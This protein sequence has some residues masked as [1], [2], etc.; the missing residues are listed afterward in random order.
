M[1]F[2]F[3]FVGDLLENG[4]KAITGALG[5]LWEIIWDEILNPILEP[6]MGLLGIEDE[7][8]LQVSVS[9]APYFDPDEHFISTLEKGIIKAILDDYDIFEGA[10]LAILNNITT[11][12]RRYYN[13]GLIGENKITNSIP[14]VSVGDGYINGLPEGSMNNA[15]INAVNDDVLDILYSL[16]ADAITIILNNLTVR[17]PTIVEQV[18]NAL[19]ASEPTWD[20]TQY[21]ESDVTRPAPIPC[22]EYTDVCVNPQPDPTFIINRYW[23]FQGSPTD[24]N[25]HGATAY[26]S[27][28][29]VCQKNAEGAPGLDSCLSVS[30]ISNCGQNSIQ[31]WETI[32]SVKPAY[33]FSYGGSTFTEQKDIEPA[34]CPHPT[35]Q[36]YC[37]STAP[38]TCPDEIYEQQCTDSWD[39]DECYQE[40]VNCVTDGGFETGG[41]IYAYD[42]DASGWP[43]IDFLNTTNDLITNLGC[44]LT[45]QDSMWVTQNN[46]QIGIHVGTGLPTGFDSNDWDYTYQNADD[47]GCTGVGTV[48]V[49]HEKPTSTTV[50]VTDVCDTYPSCCPPIDKT[51]WDTPDCWREGVN[52]TPDPYFYSGDDYYRSFFGSQDWGQTGGNPYFLTGTQAV[53]NEIE[54]YWKG[55]LGYFDAWLVSMEFDSTFPDQINYTVGY[56]EVSGGNTYTSGPNTMQHNNCAYMDQQLYPCNQPQPDVCDTY[57]QC[58]EP[59]GQGGEICDCA[60]LTGPNGSSY[61]YNETTERYDVVDQTLDVTWEYTSETIDENGDI[62]A[63]FVDTVDPS[64]TITRAISQ[65]STDIFYV[66]DYTITGGS[67]DGQTLTW[68]YG[69]SEGTYPQLADNSAYDDTLEDGYQFLPVVCLKKN[70]A[71]IDSNTSSVDYLTTRY[72]CKQYDISLTAMIDAVKSNTAEADVTDAFLVIG[73]NIYQDNH[74]VNRYLLAFFAAMSPQ[75]GVTKSDWDAAIANPAIVDAPYNALAIREQHYN[76]VVQFNYIDIQLKEGTIGYVGYTQKDINVA[77]TK[78]KNQTDSSITIRLQYNASQYYEMT[79]RGLSALHA[80]RSTIGQVKTKAIA[81]SNDASERKNFTIPVSRAVWL[82][83]GNMQTKEELIYRS[84]HFVIYA[85][86]ITHLEW[87]ETEA[88]ADFFKIVIIIVSIALAIPTGGQSINWGQLAINFLVQLALTEAL[89]LV[90]ASTDDPTL[91]AIAYVLYAVA[92]SYNYGNNGFELQFDSA[93]MLNTVGAVFNGMKEFELAGLKEEFDDFTEAYDKIQEELKKAE[94]EGPM[95]PYADLVTWIKTEQILHYETPDQFYRRTL[96]T[97]PGLDSISLLTKF[98]DNMLELPRLDPRVDTT[99]LMIAPTLLSS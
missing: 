10:K 83:M 90:L 47:Y 59:D 30:C 15:N 52:C 40:G 33:E 7:T 74:A 65:V 31:R 54:Y 79:V 58:C 18:R 53:N 72:L 9:T 67:Q 46:K 57:P 88:F 39:T 1:G 28:W 26:E 86:Q 98:Y 4:W 94:D 36:T 22:A 61:T 41:N 82:E 12:T 63:T 2:V 24:E 62:V 5:D 11:S 81:M 20:G 69:L 3:D 50:T 25:L 75:C 17:Y 32:A 76:F 93:A 70:F 6:I 48:T 97:N 44:L 37:P 60:D 45:T 16:H 68:Y 43:T 35:D 8:I 56:Q 95:S 29:N 96:N 78:T 55:F 23:R 84:L 77:T 21:I 66:A 42:G 85:E 34:S 51:D 64:Y 91:R 99:D 73:A 92:S 19:Q 80:V 49:L 27:A 14:I 71:Y 89:K 38:E 13:Y 87:Y